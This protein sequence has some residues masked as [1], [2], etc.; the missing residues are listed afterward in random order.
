[1]VNAERPFLADL[2]VLPMPAWDLV[3]V[4]RYLY[5]FGKSQ[6]KLVLVTS[7]G[8]LFRCSFCYVIDFHNRKYRGR[9]AGRILEEVD[10]LQKNFGIDAVRFDDDLFV[11]D[12][13]RLREFC[14]WIDRKDSRWLVVPRLSTRSARG[15]A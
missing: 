2:D 3:P 6:R 8:C 10:Y 12:R 4:E 14:D 7:R 9:S 11:I 13:L 5:R 15:F 1:M